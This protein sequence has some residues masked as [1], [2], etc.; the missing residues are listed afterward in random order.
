MAGST[1]VVTSHL[2][3]TSQH[4]HNEIYSIQIVYVTLRFCLFCAILLKMLQVAFFPYIY[5][6]SFIR[7]SHISLAPMKD[8]AVKFALP[9]N[10][11]WNKAL[12]NILIFLAGWILKETENVCV[13]GGSDFLK[14]MVSI[15]RARYSN[16]VFL[17]PDL[18]PI[19]HYYK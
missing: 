15:K 2:S 1:S 6:A 12:G 17:I 18:Y 13:W 11:I 16:I 19:V 5:M 7:F 9:L 4:P 3:S 8:S 10:C 14:F